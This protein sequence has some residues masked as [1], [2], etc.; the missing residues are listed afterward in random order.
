MVSQDHQVL[1]EQRVKLEHQADAGLQG[2]QENRAGRVNGEKEDKLGHRDPREPQAVR[3]QPVR[4]ES[5]E[6]QVRQER[7]EQ[8]ELQEHGVSGVGK[9][10]VDLQVSLVPLETQVNQDQLVLTA[11]LVREVLQVHPVQLV[12]LVLPV[13]RDSKDDRDHK[14][15][16]AQREIMD[17]LVNVD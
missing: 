14:E 6:R 1:K 16:R 4:L 11:K 9:E 15:Q 12:P 8:M 5:L 17:L 2:Y 10:I 13:Y 7:V 3:D